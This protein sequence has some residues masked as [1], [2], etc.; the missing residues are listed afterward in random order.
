MKVIRCLQLTV[1]LAVI[2]TLAQSVQAACTAS[3]TVKS[4]SG[5]GISGVWIEYCLVNTQ[6]GCSTDLVRFAST[7]SYGNFSGSILCAPPFS[8]LDYRFFTWTPC[9]QVYPFSITKTVSAG[10]SITGLDF[11]AAAYT[12]K[13]AGKVAD[14]SGVGISGIFMNGFPSNTSTDS[15]GLYSA[16]VPCNWG[17]KVTPSDSCYVFSPESIMYSIVQESHTDQNYTGNI[18]TYTISGYVKTAAGAGI[19]GVTIRNLPGNPVTNSS[20]FYSATV[21]CGGQYSVWPEKTGLTFTPASIAYHPI[22]SNQTNQNFTADC[23]FSVHIPAYISGFGGSWN[24]TQSVTTTPADCAWSLTGVPSWITINSGAAGTG[25]GTIN[26]TLAA[27]PG[28]VFEQATLRIGNAQAGATFTI[29]QNGQNCTFTLMP[30]TAT[31]PKTG[32]SGAFAIATPDTCFWSAPSSQPTWLSLGSIS[33]SN[34]PFGLG[35]RMGSGGVGY[36][37]AANN[38]EYERTGY[39]GY[40]YSFS[41]KQAGTLTVALPA[42]IVGSGSYFTTLQEAHDMAESG[43]TIEA[44]A[45]DFP[46]GLTA[47]KHLTIIGGFDSGYTSNN[48][49]STLKGLTIHDG[50]LTVEMLRIR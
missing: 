12:F 22:R 37:L 3:G 11:S 38:G 47:T 24:T 48:G 14:G 46:D 41:A 45:V 33:A 13:I 28:T 31:Y 10:D 21:P 25:N 17:H 4:A 34:A 39:I 18:L 30:P 35:Y 32:G 44:Q 40:P 50:S 16:T 19:P 26:F 5:A 1:I 2:L 23:T 20:G 49:Y 42:W 8:H 29:V 27:N 7:D 9:Y 36:G 15:A 43:N 6:G